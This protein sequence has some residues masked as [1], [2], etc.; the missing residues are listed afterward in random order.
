MVLDIN[1]IVVISLILLVV[2]SLCTFAVVLPI[3][4]QLSKTLG[5]AQTLLDTINDDLEP[6][7]REIKDSV[8]GVKSIV[9]KG[10][11]GVQLGV[12]ETSVALTSSVYGVLIGVKE[13]FSSY[14]KEKNSYNGNG[15][16]D[17]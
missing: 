3:S 6:T 9:S 15:K 8:V 16:E 14:K 4:M 10:A 11:V 2:I 7:V 13:Y 17:G 12:S 1:H 5:S